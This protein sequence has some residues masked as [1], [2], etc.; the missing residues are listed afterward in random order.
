VIVTC[1][2]LLSGSLSSTGL[3]CSFVVL[4]VAAWL[5][6]Y[7][8][9]ESHFSGAYLWLSGLGFAGL[10]FAVTATLPTIVNLYGKDLTF[11]GR[12]NI[13]AATIPAIKANPIR[14]YGF[15]G[16]FFNHAIEPTVSIDRRAGFIAWHAHN[17]V[18]EMLLEGG[19]IGLVLYIS[20][21]WS[22]ISS[23]WRALRVRTDV[24]KLML[25]YATMQF[26]VGL[27]EVA[28]LGG[29]IFIL[30]L[31][32]G[33]LATATRTEHVTSP[34]APLASRRRVAALAEL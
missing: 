2:P 13:W 27:S 3:S 20:F 4:V 25:L 17:S 24:A 6:A 5:S 8:R 7:L 23:A 10:L 34:A 29:W 14:G 11:S 12:T 18:L 31:L 19:L 26:V 32:R 15:G 1:R 21:F 22:M 28:L 16:V 30:V 9:Q 33:M